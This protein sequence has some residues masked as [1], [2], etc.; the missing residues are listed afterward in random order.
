L[1]EGKGLVT[2]SAAIMNDGSIYRPTAAFH[3][4]DMYILAPGHT[5]DDLTSRITPY[6]DIEALVDKEGI[7]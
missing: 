4:L 2:G 6:S 1:S 5:V 7:R 3:D